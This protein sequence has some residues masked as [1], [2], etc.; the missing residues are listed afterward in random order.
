MFVSLTCES[1][2]RTS[3]NQTKVIL[4]FHVLRFGEKG[5]VNEGRSERTGGTQA[6][7]LLLHHIKLMLASSYQLV[8]ETQVRIIH[9]VVC[10]GNFIKQHEFLS[11][12]HTHSL[13]HTHFS[14]LRNENA[15]CKN[16]FCHKSLNFK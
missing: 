9:R 6:E 8:R 13:T 16:L 2:S 15:K 1:V 14:E 3:V 5:I 10:T 4:L 12:P 11:F 7:T